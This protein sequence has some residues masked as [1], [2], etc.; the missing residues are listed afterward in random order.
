MNILEVVEACGAG[1]GRH[2]RGLCRDLAAQ[3]HRLTVAYSP[4]RTDEA[5]RRFIV[6]QQSKIRFVPLNIGQKVSPVSDLRGIFQLLRL[7]RLEGPFDIVH[8][9]SSKGGAVARIAGRCFGVSTV[10]TPHSVV[11]ASPE[12]SRGGVAVYTLI[13]RVLGH[14]ATSKVIAVSEDEREFILRLGL[15]PE[16]RVAVIENGLDDRVF[17]YF[18]RE[19]DREDTGQRPLTFGS[20]MRFSP[21]KA[22]G[23]LI[24]AFVRLVEMSPQVPVRLMVAGDGELFAEIKK[25]AAATGLGEKISLPGWREDARDVLRDLDVFV[26]SSLYEGFSYAIL[27][28]MA[29]KLPIVSTNVFGT[30]ETVAQVPGNVLIPVG[31]PEALAQG[32]KQMTVP[33]ESGSVRRSLQR[34]GQANH[35]YARTHF[36]QSETTRRTLEIYKALR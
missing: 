32:M 3:G 33:T 29:A 10:Y 5:F 25:Q 22:P 17:E 21:Q 24:E 28:A 27:E 6:D 31:D 35:D 12:I 8:G 16:D 36:R 11:M 20:I 4:H 1:V 2:V 7:I 9:H 18:S 14:W 30:K 34:I 15:V 19:A 23:H 26:L 13:E